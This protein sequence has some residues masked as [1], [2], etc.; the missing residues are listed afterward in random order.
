M[1]LDGGATS[2]YMYKN[3]ENK[4]MA[5]PVWDFDWAYGSY[6]NRDGVNLVEGNS[7]YIRNKKMY[8]SKDFAIMAKLCSHSEFWD[9]V[10]DEWNNSFKRY[11]N[12]QLT[13]ENLTSIDEYM[14]KYKMSA[15]MN[16]TRFDIL[17]TS[18]IWGSSDTGSTYEDNIKFLKEFYKR[19]IDFLDEN[20][21]GIM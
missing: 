14:E 2:F 5:G 21:N 20:F 16:F 11:V 12:A 15:T 4:L 19:R 1:N 13:G 10:K 3:G 17:P 7:W 6:E 9:K 8:D 18:Y